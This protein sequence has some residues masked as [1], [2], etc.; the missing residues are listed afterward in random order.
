[1]KVKVGMNPGMD[2][3]TVWAG[4]EGDWPGNW[5]GVD[6]NGGWSTCEA[7]QTIQ[8]LADQETLCR[9]AGPAL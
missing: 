5:L 1:M 9:V 6:A 4:A 8:R 7:I 3:E 2:L